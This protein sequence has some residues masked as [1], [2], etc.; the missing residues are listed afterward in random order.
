MEVSDEG[1]QHLLI[2]CSFNIL[3]TKYSEVLET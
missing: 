1:L 3:L 2:G